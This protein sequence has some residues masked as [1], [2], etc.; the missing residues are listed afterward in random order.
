MAPL[1]VLVLGS[2]KALLL[3]AAAAAGAAMLQRKPARL[4]VVVWATALGGTLLIPL[5]T[6]VLPRLELPVLPRLGMELLPITGAPVATAIE[7]AEA[8]PALDEFSGREAPMPQP[9]VLANASPRWPTLMLLGWAA[10]TGIALA[11]L[12]IALWCTRRLIRHASPTADPAWLADLARARRRVGLRRAVRMVISHQIEIPAT[13]GVLRPT[14]ILP[15]SADTWQPE[16]REAVLLHEL[17]HVSRLDWPLRLVARLARACYWFNPL[18]WWAVRRLDLEQELACDE[19]V[20]ALGTRPSVY[21]CHLLGIARAIARHP[22]PAIAGLEMARACHLEERIMSILKATTRRRLG[23]RVLIPAAVLVGALVPALAAVVPTVTPV[24]PETPPSPQAPAV[25]PAPPAAP[26]LAE[27]LAEMKAVE[28]RMQ[29]QLDQIEAIEAEMA[30][31]LEEISS[32]ADAIDDGAIADIEAELQPYLERIEAIELDTAPVE[33]EMEAIEERLE[34]IEL[35]IDDGPLEE[36]ERQI[37]EQ[38]EPLQEELERLEAAM[39]PQLEQIEAIQ[40]EMEPVHEKLGAFH[41]QLEPQQQELERVHAGMEPFHDQMDAIHQELEPLHEEM[42]RLG[43]RLEKAIGDEVAAVLRGHLA[44]V[45]DAQAPLR[46]VAGQLLDD[47]SINVHGDVVRVS[48]SEEAAREILS[49]RLGP[50]RIGSPG[51]FDAAVAAAAAAVS[52]LEITAR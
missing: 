35:H 30:P 3:L 31:T 2:F 24:S 26:D 14:I 46:A 36:V 43:E 22:A 27:I 21:A 6:P 45:T 29:P 17:V 13:V 8:A 18:A 23:R 5:V 39:A 15:T 44:S 19:E 7:A 50:H 28:E 51:A 40:R 32:I 38:L 42:E 25:T 10:G 37:R 11:R 12:G 16:R 20:V 48:M 41:E 34:G 33:A 52:D 9:T 49:S 1:G 4:R 47:A